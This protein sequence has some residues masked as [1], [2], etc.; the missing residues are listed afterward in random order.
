MVTFA[1]I[2]A[3]VL[4][5][6]LG[7]AHSILGEKHII[8]WLL[9][10]DLPRLLGGV[11]FTAGTI[12]FAWHLTTVLFLGL[13]GVLLVVTL[14]ASAS[15]VLMVVGS[16]FVLCAVLPIWFTRGRHISWVILL[17]AGGLCFWG[18]VTI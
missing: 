4:I 6:L 18:A 10:H 17:V 5:A 13:A 14:G 11:S 8:R 15:A 1:L 3:A 16:T 7:V 9:A 2:A 12:R